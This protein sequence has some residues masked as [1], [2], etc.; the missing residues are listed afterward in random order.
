M[1]SE[2]RQSSNSSALLSTTLCSRGDEYTSIL[3]PETTTAPLPSSSVPEG[4]PLR[5]EVSKTCWNAE[6]EGV[7]CRKGRGVDHRVAGFGGGV[8]LGED[9]FGESFGDSRL[10]IRL[11]SVL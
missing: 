5:G 9:F 7:V 6:E 1:V 2:R 8:H 10:G 4:L 3:S 11:S